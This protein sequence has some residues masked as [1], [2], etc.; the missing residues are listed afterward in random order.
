MTLDPSLLIS[1]WDAIDR[2]SYTTASVSPSAN[3][4]LCVDVYS[5]DDAGGIA[6]PTITGLSL[7]WTTEFTKT[8]A[9]G[10]H[11]ITR[12]YARTGSSPGSGTITLNW[13]AAT[14]DGAGWFVY[15]LGTDVD[16]S[17]PFVQTLGNTDAGSVTS[18]T[19]TLAAFGD[20]A[21]RPLIS[22]SHRANEGSTPEAGYTEVGDLNGAN[23][24]IGFALAYHPS[25][26]DTTPSYSW[27]TIGAPAVAVAS[28]MRAA[29]GGAVVTDPFG[30]SGFFGG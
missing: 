18:I 10:A 2:T 24:L 3:S 6:A 23:P 25:T 5:R 28:E 9:S 21:N 11:Q 20:P 17:D 13:G 19:V 22:A 12:A 29:P 14:M 1:A 4:W 26:T 16:P 8:D 7:T 15:Q 30:M 27:A